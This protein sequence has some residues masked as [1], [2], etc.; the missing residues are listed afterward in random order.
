MNVNCGNCSHQIVGTLSGLRNEEGWHIACPECGTSVTMEELPRRII[1]VFD[2]DETGEHFTDDLLAD[3]RS[4]DFEAFETPKEFLDSW[5]VLVQK[6]D[7]MWYWIIDNGEIFC[8]GPVDVNDIYCIVDHFDGE[9][10]FQGRPSKIQEFN[11]TVSQK[12]VLTVEDIDDIMVGALEGGINYWCKEAE[13]I[14]EKR[15][16]AWGHEQIARG[17]VLMLH[18]RYED[19]VYELT[20]TKFI[21]GFQKWFENGGYES[22]AVSGGKV[23]CC[24][25]DAIEADMI[26]QYALFGKLVCC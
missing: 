3:T 22:G 2:F 16:A 24:L 25:I 18:D 11:I 4:R 15:V 13:V 14:E 17:G 26:V 23:D 21:A 19:E 8:S 20:R 7:G 5:K 12:V 1:M 9:Q 6:P 10:L